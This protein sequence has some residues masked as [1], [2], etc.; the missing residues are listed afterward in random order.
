MKSSHYPASHNTKGHT[1][2]PSEP[3]EITGFIQTK[4]VVICNPLCSLTVCGWQAYGAIESDRLN[5]LSAHGRLVHIIL[6]SNFV[7]QNG[8][9]VHIQNSPHLI[10]S[11][12]HIRTVSTAV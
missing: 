4:S 12:I 10:T 1:N 6:N 2:Q 8:I 7:T 11:H 9:A 3:S 5:A